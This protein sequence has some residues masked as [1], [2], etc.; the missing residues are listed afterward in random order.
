MATVYYSVNTLRDSWTGNFTVNNPADLVINYDASNPSNFTAGSLSFGVASF[1]IYPGDNNS[2][3]VTWRSAIPA[4]N[5]QYPSTGYS[6]DIWSSILYSDVVG[7]ITWNGLMGRTAEY[8][9]LNP[10]KWSLVYDYDVPNAVY[11]GYSGS[12]TFSATPL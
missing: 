7:G 4:D 11:Y 2:D 6:V 9:T 10:N 12:I 5:G 8:Y 1:G 3:Y